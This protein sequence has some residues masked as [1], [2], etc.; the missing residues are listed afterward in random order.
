MGRQQVAFERGAG[1][2]CRVMRVLIAAIA[3]RLPPGESNV[4]ASL[5]DGAGPVGLRPSSEAV[6]KGIDGA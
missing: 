6:N 1:K 2:I 3:Y 5:P 4:V